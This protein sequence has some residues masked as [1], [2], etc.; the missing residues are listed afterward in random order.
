MC[1][2]ELIKVVVFCCKAGIP[3]GALIVERPWSAR[4]WSPGFSGPEPNGNGE[5]APWKCGWFANPALY[6]HSR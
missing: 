3:Q 2:M 6:S 4:A 5:P 1:A